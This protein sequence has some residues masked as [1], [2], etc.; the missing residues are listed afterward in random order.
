MRRTAKKL[1]TTS[2]VLNFF[3]QADRLGI[4]S[5]EGCI[6][7]TR[8][9]RYCISSHLQVCIK[10]CRLDDIQLL[11]KLMICNSCGIDDIQGSALIVALRANGFIFLFLTKF[12]RKYLHC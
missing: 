6:S 4:S 5:A 2:V 8:Q 3:I 12:F 1:R 9:S 10:I 11:A 7:S